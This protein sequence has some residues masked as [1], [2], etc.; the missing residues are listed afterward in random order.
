MNVFRKDSGIGETETDD[1]AKKN[2][3]AKKWT[4]VVRLQRKVMELEGKNKRLQDDMDRYGS[5]AKYAKGKLRKDYMPKDPARHC[6][7]GHRG[8]VTCVSF[9]PDFTVVATSAEDAAVKLWDYETG[10]F[11]RT[12]KSHINAVNHVDFNPKGTL[13]ASCSADLSIKL[14][15]T[16]TYSVIK[17]L[18]GHDHNV[19]A[20]RFLPSGALFSCS[21][22]STIRLWDPSTGFSTQMLTG[23]DGWIRDV[24]CSADGGLLASCS[25]SQT[26]VVWKMPAG[27]KMTTLTGHEHV[28]E[29]VAFSNANFDASMKTARAEAE[30]KTVIDTG[31]K[32]EAGSGG[33]FLA[34]ASR[35][36]T[37]RVWDV[38]TGSCVA[39]LTGHDNWVRGVAFHPEGRFVLSVSDDRTLRVWDVAKRKCTRTIRDAHEHFAQCIAIHP[40]L[41]LIATG[42]VDAVAKIWEGC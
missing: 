15:S 17:T 36:K 40:K 31:R 35:D 32:N 42:G 20:A 5:S 33:R 8:I 27:V 25:T 3:L 24:V 23:Q 11:E 38:N 37:I 9:H 12:L 39:V 41:P 13:L 26:I 22:D 6:L 30:G 28:V 14:W 7:K 19:S 1:A 4:A 18:V 29:A 16:K 2:L 34:S 10:E 21:R